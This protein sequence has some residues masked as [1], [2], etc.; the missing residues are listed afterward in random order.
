M[1][2]IEEFLKS[3]TIWTQSKTD[4]VRATPAQVAEACRKAGATI[5][6]GY[7]VGTAQHE[8]NCAINE[9]DTEENGY[10]S[11]GI[12][13][14]GYH[15]ARSVKMPSANLLDLDQSCRVMV[16]LA[17]NRRMYLRSILR[18]VNGQA[19]SPDLNAYIAIC[20]NVGENDAT[21]KNIPKYGMDWKEWKRRNLQES[22]AGLSGATS[23][24]DMIKKS[25][26]STKMQEAEAKFQKAK[27][28][29][30]WVPKMAAYGDDCLKPWP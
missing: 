16:M 8:S 25:G 12:F 1:A 13:Q 20:H 3:T 27:T 28:Y 23:M 22:Q 14:L 24:L 30:I 10:M 5:P 29:A 7:F 26:D 21:I 18:L 19:D 4:A 6:L 2:R 17:E 15:E 11:Y 9:R